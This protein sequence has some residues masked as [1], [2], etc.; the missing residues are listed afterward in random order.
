MQRPRGQGSGF[1]DDRAAARP[2]HRSRAV[3]THNP[4]HG[5]PTSLS[6]SSGNCQRTVNL[7]K[8]SGTVVAIFRA[9]GALQTPGGGPGRV[10]QRIPMLPTAPHGGQFRRRWRRVDVL[11]PARPAWHGPG[12]QERRRFC[13]TV[14]P[15]MPTAQ[16]PVIR[17]LT[18][19]S[20]WKTSPPRRLASVVP[21]PQPTKPP[22]IPQQRFLTPC[23]SSHRRSA[24]LRGRQTWQRSRSRS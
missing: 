6:F 24:P 16:P 2:A 12:R 18:R 21:S 23:R 19:F 14:F 17:A 4:A 22:T 10:A 20:T 5:G 7:E 9:K 8:V 11:H 15:T 1:H 13:R 3:D